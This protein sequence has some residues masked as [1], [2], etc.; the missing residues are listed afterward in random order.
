MRTNI[1]SNALGYPRVLAALFALVL[2]GNAFSQTQTA[3]AKLPVSVNV[4]ANVKIVPP[5]GNDYTG[6]GAEGAVTGGAQ[7]EFD[8]KLAEMSRNAGATW[9]KEYTEENSS[10]RHRSQRLAAAGAW[11][12]H[13]R[14]SVNLSLNPQ[15]YQNAAIALHSING[16]RILSSKA[17]ASNGVLNLSPANIPAGV[18][19][20]SVKGAKGRSFTTRLTHSGNRLNINIAFAGENSQSLKKSAADEAHIYGTWSIIVSA[21][22]YSSQTRSFNP[23]AGMNELKSFTLVAPPALAKFTETVGDASFDMIY[24]EGGTFT[25]GCEQSSGCPQDTRA[26]SDVAVSSYFIGETEITRGMW[27]AVMGG[28]APNQC[29][30]FGSSGVNCNNVPVNTITWY[31]A[32]EFV[33]KLSQLT[34]RNYRL[35]TEAEW[36]FAAKGGKSGNHSFIYSGSNTHDDVAASGGGYGGVAVKSK[37]PNQL[38]IYDMSGSMDEWTYNTWNGSH[39]GGK[40]P[41][42]PGGSLHNQKTRR[43][44]S[45]SEGSMTRQVSAR[46]IRSIEGKDGAIGMRIALSAEKDLPPGMVHPCNIHMPEMHDG[47]YVNS[48]RDTR[49]ITGDEYEWGGGF[50]NTIIK[51]WET[52]EAVMGMPMEC[53]W[54]GC[55]GGT[56]CNNGMMMVGGATGEWYTVNNMAFKIAPASDTATRP[57]FAYI[58]VSLD[59]VSVISASSG[60][61]IG[62]LIKQPASRNVPKPAI[63]S[64]RTVAQLATQADDKMYDMSNIPMSAR[65]Q[66]ERLLDGTGYGW[67]QENATAGTHKYRKDVDKDEFRF[68]VYT[69]SNPE[70]DTTSSG[71]I[72]AN[73]TWFT[74][75][76]TFLRVTHPTSGY[77]VD[78]L[79]DV[80]GGSTP[81][82]YHVSFMGYE[83][84]DFRGLV[85]TANSSVKGYKHEIPKDQATS[86]YNTMNNGHS[87]YEPPKCPAGGCN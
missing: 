76:N 56:C 42:G 86:M 78:Y 18:Y 52:G 26:V 1:G 16:K 2:A 64:P 61:P 34:G 58:F 57:K 31:D 53:S 74:V 77:T 50:G 19:L 73:G 28:T 70:V 30:S 4:S 38:G 23:I 22:G 7:K 82:F 3:D 79:Y 21:D 83:R 48:Y 65:Q 47:D 39:S 62:R 17:S 54:N 66:D 13:S 5:P 9:D 46:R 72:L 81:T 44:G 55:F 41:L 37:A 20:L 63:S 51:V 25:L 84:G 36:E 14:G 68:I 6:T 12:S 67:W 45:S 69:P 10:V 60:A 15:Q 80:T 87:T 49:W 85:K 35:A 8:I 24:V 33:C 11:V 43:G 71:V 59:E 32:N 27:V 75:N 29:Y 40:D